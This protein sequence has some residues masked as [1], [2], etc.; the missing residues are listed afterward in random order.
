LAFEWLHLP[1]V[2][3]HL[4]KS[5][6]SQVLLSEESRNVGC[7]QCMSIEASGYGE[8]R[9]DV[10][11]SVAID[12]LTQQVAKEGVAGSQVPVIDVQARTSQ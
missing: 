11:T 3:E 8:G 12:T 4:D 2:L 1:F 6:D 7:R 10:G 5:I 9:S